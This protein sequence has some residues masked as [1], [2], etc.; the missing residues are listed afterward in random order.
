MNA[1]TDDIER[2]I[3]EFFEQNL[4]ELALEMGHA[5]SPEVREIARQQVHMYWRKLRHIAERVTDAE[6]RLTL[7]QQRTPKG[8]HLRHRGRG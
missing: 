2:R 3:D 8:A 6:V 7:P 5:L 1:L 4:A